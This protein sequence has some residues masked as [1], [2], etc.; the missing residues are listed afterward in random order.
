MQLVHYFFQG[1]V[2]ESETIPNAFAFPDGGS[3]SVTLAVFLKHFPASANTYGGQLHFRFRAEDVKCGYVWLD[4]TSPNAVLPTFKGL[5]TAKVLCL[6]A[7]TS[8]R[9]L[10]RLKKKRNIDSNSN[11]VG[12]VAGVRNGYGKMEPYGDN[13]AGPTRT[14]KNASSS[15]ESTSN[16]LNQGDRGRTAD[17][18]AATAE[19]KQPSENLMDFGSDEVQSAVAVAGAAASAAAAAKTTNRNLDQGQLA[20]EF[21]SMG[22]DISGASTAAT[23]PLNREELVAKREA[24]IQ[25]KVNQ[26]LEFKQELDENQKRESEELETAKQKHDKILTEWAFDQSKKKRNVRTLLSTMHKVLW[27]DSTWKPV[28]LGDIIE[29]KKVKLQF[30]K[31]M[32]V[33]HPDRCAN[34]SAENRFIGKRVFEG[35]ND[36]YQEFLKSESVE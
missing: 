12:V 7:K 1:E 23:A 18:V 29:P 8:S 14:G 25:E 10:A 17:A 19:S 35:I 21:S 28:G 9:R 3:Q 27:S 11:D 22:I 34:L 24:A 16:S 6:D 15:S 33:V 30:R 36:A 20:S 5:I 31:A 13:P 2:G 4:V 26:A 32:L